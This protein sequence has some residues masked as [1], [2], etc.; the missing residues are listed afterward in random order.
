[1]IPLWALLALAF[2]FAGALIIGFNQVFKIDGRVLVVWRLLGILPVAVAAWWFLPWPT[3]W[4][5]YALSAALGVASTVGDVLLYN[6]SAKHGGR[7][8]ALYVPMKMLIGFVLWCLVAP[9][10][11]WILVANPVHMV[12]IL[13][14]FAGAFW[15]LLHIRR[16]DASWRGL[17]AVLPVAL[18]FAG[19]DVIEKLALPHGDMMMTLGYTSAMLAVLLSVSAIPA[20]IGLRGKLPT[21]TRTVVASAGFGV[22]LMVGIGVLLVSLVTAPNPGY[23]GAVSS[24]S[25]VWL[26]LW[27]RVRQGERN[28]LSAILALVASAVGVVVLVSTLH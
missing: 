16:S 11:F 22:L 20:F 15:A 21:D 8:A 6:A 3:E 26:A 25:V 5:F 27:A 1:M 23:V 2:S 24:L 10:S 19:E 9:E 13:A 17:L 12:G 4:W 7:L 28:N 18:I 14:C